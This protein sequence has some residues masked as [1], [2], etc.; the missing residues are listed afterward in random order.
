MSSLTGP[1]I[2]P[3]R[4]L[5]CI[6]YTSSDL[7]TQSQRQFAS[8]LRLLSGNSRNCPRREYQGQSLRVLIS[9]PNVYIISPWL[10]IVPNKCTIEP[11]AD[12]AS[13]I[14]WPYL[15]Q[16]PESYNLRVY[17]DIRALNTHFLRLVHGFLFSFPKILTDTGPFSFSS[18]TVHH[19]KSVEKRQN[20]M[21]SRSRPGKYTVHIFLRSS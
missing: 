13:L 4:Y 5:G 16:K 15:N 3:A 11:T 20:Q 9:A 14:F 6:C 18:P 21:F 7:Q 10:K 1:H 17:I 19:F 12:F 2:Q 8:D